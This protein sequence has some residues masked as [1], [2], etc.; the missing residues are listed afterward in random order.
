[1]GLAHELSAGSEDLATNW[2]YC[3]GVAHGG[4][5]P[6]RRELW[7]ATLPSLNRFMGEMTPEC[8]LS[9]HFGP[10][11]ATFERKLCCVHAPLLRQLNPELRVPRVCRVADGRRCIAS[12][13]CFGGLLARRHR[14]TTSWSVASKL[15]YEQGDNSG[16]RY[17][18]ISL[19]IDVSTYHTVVGY[20]PPRSLWGSMGYLLLLRGN[21]YGVL[22]TEQKP[23]GRA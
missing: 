5:I 23:R 13:G 14:K 15:E 8:E 18:N 16:L 2:G 11:V 12:W 19:I 10:G 9:S 4:N 1:V 7:V 6:V 21:R 3:R 22:L 20:I 17:V